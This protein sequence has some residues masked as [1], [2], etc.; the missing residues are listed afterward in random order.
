MQGREASRPFRQLIIIICVCLCLCE[1]LCTWQAQTKEAHANHISAAAAA[2]RTQ[3]RPWKRAANKGAAA[4][5]CAQYSP[6]H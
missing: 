5:G 1:M 3:M 6:L 2:G 4:A